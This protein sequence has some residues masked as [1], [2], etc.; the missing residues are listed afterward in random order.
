MSMQS[1]KSICASVSGISSPVV[2]DSVSILTCFYYSAYSKSSLPTSEA[3]V[4][5]STISV[6]GLDRLKLRVQ[7]LKAAQG[8]WDVKT[9]YRMTTPLIR[10]SMSLEEFKKDWGVE[11]SEA[12][13]PTPPAYKVS[14]ELE[15]ICYCGTFPERPGVLRCVLVVLVT[16]KETPGQRESQM[17]WGCGSTLG[18]SGTGATPITMGPAKRVPPFAREV[19]QPLW[20]LRYQRPP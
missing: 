9:W 13:S 16:V 3:P 5:S 8:A 20:K 11:S 12:P 7:T 19:R 1:K 18:A 10:E 15:A 2:Q 6:P 14:G 17:L 4:N